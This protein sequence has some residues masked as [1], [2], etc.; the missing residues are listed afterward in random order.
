MLRRGEMNL[1]ERNA[2][3]KDI[4]WLD[5]VQQHTVRDRLDLTGLVV[6]KDNRTMHLRNFLTL[7]LRR[8]V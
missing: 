8:R 1:N 4:F 5:L 6:R 2:M 7:T 3:R